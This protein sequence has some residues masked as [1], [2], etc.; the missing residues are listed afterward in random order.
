MRDST[1]PASRSTRR[2]L[3]TEGCDSRSLRSISPTDRS[4]ESSRLRMARRLGSATMAKDDSTADIYVVGYIPVKACNGQ[5][6]P[7]DLVAIHR[8]CVLRS[9]A[10]AAGDGELS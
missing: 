4:D 9:I 5:P 10:P 3:E 2:C 1:K 6:A 8:R 7:S